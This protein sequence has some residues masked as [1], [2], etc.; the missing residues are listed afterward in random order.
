LKRRFVLYRRKLGGT[1]YVENMETRKQ[2]SPGT[3]NRAETTSLLNAR[4]ESVRHRN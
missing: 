2:E 3:K 4:N 1:F